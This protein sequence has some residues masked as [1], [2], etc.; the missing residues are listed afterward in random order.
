MLNGLCGQAES[1]VESGRR[2]EGEMPFRRLRKAYDKSPLEATEHILPI[3]S[4]T[5][6]I[7]APQR[8]V[9]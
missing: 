4:S 2:F 8:S 5:E 1:W 7:V 3:P 9:A 6:R